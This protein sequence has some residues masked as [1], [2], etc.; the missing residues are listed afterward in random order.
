[1]SNYLCC[2]LPSISELDP[3]FSHTV[4]SHA[5]MYHNQKQNQT[6][7]LHNTLIGYNITQQQPASQFSMS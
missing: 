2:K 6:P 7:N 3:V 1:M 5:N 4:K